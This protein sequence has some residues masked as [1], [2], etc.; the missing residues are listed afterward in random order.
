MG[1][2]RHGTG[3]EAKIKVDG[4]QRYLGLFSSEE[5]AARAYDSVALQYPGQ[6]GRMRKLN[7]PPKELQKEQDELYNNPIGKTKKPQSNYKTK[8][9]QPP[10]HIHAE[11]VYSK[12]IAS[13]SMDNET[14]S[15]NNNINA[16][17]TMNTMNTDN[18]TKETMMEEWAEALVG[19]KMMQ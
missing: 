14:A 4:E 19:L 18:N 8:Q 17:N 13:S 16:M 7:F 3:W 15:N 5:E 12:S 2:G 11:H 9:Q 10:L 1:V 6:W